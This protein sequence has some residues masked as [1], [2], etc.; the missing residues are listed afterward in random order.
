MAQCKKC[1]A[2]RPLMGSGLCG[3]CM[4]AIPRKPYKKHVKKE[5]REKGDTGR[6]SAGLG[7][8][9]LTKTLDV[10][11]GDDLPEKGEPLSPDTTVLLIVVAAVILYFLFFQG[12]G[13]GDIHEK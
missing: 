13:G 3:S 2:D 5:K 1:G 10:L 7:S 8:E 12:R 4:K 9:R 11:C 6:V